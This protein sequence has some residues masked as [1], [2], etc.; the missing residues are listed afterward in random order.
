[1]ALADLLRLPFFEP[2]HRDHAVALDAWAATKLA[3]LLEN[4][5]ADPPGTTRRLVAALAQGGWLDA[6]VSAAPG[7]AP[8]SL[9]LCLTRDILARYGALADFAFAMQGLGSAPISLFGNTAQRERYLPDVAR[10]RKIAAFALTEPDA[11]SDVASL[12]TCARRDGD[13]YVLDG[14]KTF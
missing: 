1:M 8:D 14:T 5:E 10:G 13:H 7:A 2:R 4:D 3:G 12:S 9:T 11:G 6:S